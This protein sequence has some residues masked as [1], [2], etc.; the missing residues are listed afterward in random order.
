L[1]TDERTAFTVANVWLSAS[2]A[3][4]NWAVEQQLITA[5]PFAI[6]KVTKQRRTRERSGKTFTAEEAAIILS[7]CQQMTVLKTPMDR[8]KRWVPLLC[9]Y[10]GARAGEMTQLRGEDVQKQG[11][12][13]FAQLKP[14]AGTIKGGQAR[15][16]P[17]HE[18]LIELGFIAFVHARGR[19]PLFYKPSTS[20]ESLDP[21]NPKR[22]PAVK[23]RERLG[24]WVRKLGVT[25]PELSPSHAWR[26]T[27]LKKARQA[28]IEKSLRFGITGHAQE[29]VGDGYAEPEPDELAE[30]L[31]SFPIYDFVVRAPT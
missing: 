26:H 19:G 27:F 17:L 14:S 29:S 8:A 4:F 3:V 5:N 31:K 16:V 11:E 7:A 12:T 9:A 22:G 6:V 18:H 20:H 24:E 21:L 13:Y 30:A 2:K 10:T 23:T 15:T 28:G 25:D 1:V